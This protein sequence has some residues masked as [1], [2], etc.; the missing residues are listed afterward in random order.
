MVRRSRSVID[1]VHSL[2]NCFDD[3][4][5]M[6]AVDGNINTRWTTI[7]RVRRDTCCRM[8]PEHSSRSIFCPCT[9]VEKTK[10]AAQRM[11][12]YHRHCYRLVDF[13]AIFPTSI[14]DLFVLRQCTSRAPPR[15]PRLPAL[16]HVSHLAWKPPSP[17]DRKWQVNKGIDS[18]ILLR[19][20]INGNSVESHIPLFS[21]LMESIQVG[22][23]DFLVYV[24]RTTAAK[25]VRVKHGT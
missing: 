12:R 19:D 5:A 7:E 18:T 4:V 15:A 17:I 3:V 1:T 6:T 14:A 8:Y 21:P 22:Y 13:P 11:L 20:V 2:A 25:S 16:V 24:V 10:W 23:C 9:A